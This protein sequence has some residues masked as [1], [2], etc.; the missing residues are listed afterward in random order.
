MKPII[1]I[2][3]NISPEND[4]RRSFAKSAKL[5]YAPDGY[6]KFV[7]IGGGVP[8]I[9]PVMDDVTLA[10]NMVRG[11]DGLIVSGG[12]DLN[13]EHYSESNTH[14]MGVD[15]VRDAFEIALINAARVEA[16]AV[17]GI[18]RG[19]QVLNVA[20]GGSLYQ[21]VPTMIDGALQHHN[22]EAGKDAYHSILFTRISPL[23]EIF[24]SEEI[25]VNS[26]HHQSLKLIGKGLEVLAAA[27]DGVVEAV[28][29]PSD[30]CTFGIQWHPERMLSDPKQVQLA[31]WF[32]SQAV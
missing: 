22:W 14:S 7:E 24:Q 19:I 18:C 5:Q 17:L 32:V 16:R 20:F 8:I 27:K 13:P 1:G 3:A 21:D 9:I 30:R 11:L 12:V 29:C 4:E 28:T 26:S 6:C 23:S 15:P 2:S 10:A 25:Q 31:R